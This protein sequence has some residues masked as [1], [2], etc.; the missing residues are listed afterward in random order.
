M[1]KFLLVSI[2]A[3]IVLGLISC[4]GG[5][6]SKA[7]KVIS[8]YIK[9]TDSF[10]LK[11]QGEESN[12]L[13]LTI[14]WYTK[15][16]ENL[17]TDITEIREKF[18]ELDCLVSQVPAYFMAI[19]EM[20]VLKD[21]VEILSKKVESNISEGFGIFMESVENELN[22][23]ESDRELKAALNEMETSLEISHRKTDVIV[24]RIKDLTSKFKEKHAELSKCITCKVP[25]E[26]KELQRRMDQDMMPEFYTSMWKVMQYPANPKIKEA[27]GKFREFARR[28]APIT[29]G[30]TPETKVE[31]HVITLKENSEIFL[32]GT[33]V[34]MRKIEYMLK[35]ILKLNP[36]HA[37]AIRASKSLPYSEVIILLNHLKEIGYNK[38][39]IESYTET[40][41][42]KN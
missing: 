8:Q 18:P 42:D 36:D 23:A 29:K 20:K 16:M 38:I 15:S 31:K 5:E 17:E 28:M 30:I 35:Q 33:P 34:E 39:V 11:L 4:N 22:R 2:L 10:L 3:A 19:E 41:S 26:F 21:E 12:N 1:K 9:L 25:E 6:Y 32:D 14:D 27:I 7:K 37:I 24:K 13:A 40:T